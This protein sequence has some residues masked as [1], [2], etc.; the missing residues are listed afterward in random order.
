MNFVW[1]LVCSPNVTTGIF[2]SSQAYAK[3]VLEI[4]VSIPETD[5]LNFQK[6]M[7]IKTS[8]GREFITEL[9]IRAELLTGILLPS[10][11]TPPTPAAPPHVKMEN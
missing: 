8:A 10:Q 6:Y 5:I 9:L 4:K 7:F 1:S 11:R 3:S 2:I